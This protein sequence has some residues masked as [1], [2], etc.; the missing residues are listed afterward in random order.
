MTINAVI[1]IEVLTFF[2]G[3]VWSLVARLVGERNVIQA[4]IETTFVPEI[5]FRTAYTGMA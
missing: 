3:R 2:F 5:W 1:F 4:S